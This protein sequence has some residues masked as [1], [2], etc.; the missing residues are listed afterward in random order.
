MILKFQFFYHLW[1]NISLGLH[2]CKNTFLFFFELWLNLDSKQ[3]NK[4]LFN[5][6]LHRCEPVVVQMFEYVEVHGDHIDR[7]L[8]GRQC[9]PVLHRG[10]PRLLWQSGPHI[11]RHRLPLLHLRGLDH[12]HLLCR[13]WR[14]DRP[15]QPGS[16]HFCLEIYQA[17]VI[18]VFGDMMTVC[19]NVCDIM[20]WHLPL[21]VIG[22][23]Y[24]YLPDDCGG[25]YTGDD[26]IAPV[27]LL[28]VLLLTSSYNNNPY[29]NSY[30]PYQ[31]GYQNYQNQQLFIPQSNS[32]NYQGGY[33]TS[34]TNLIMSLTG[35]R[36]G[37]DKA[38]Q[39]S[40]SAARGGFKSGDKKDYQLLF[41][42][43]MAR[44]EKDPAIYK[45]VR[46]IKNP[47][48]GKGKVVI[49]TNDIK[50][51]IKSKKFPC[52]QLV[53]RKWKKVCRQMKKRKSSD[54]KRKH[55]KKANYSQGFVN[56]FWNSILNWNPSL[57]PYPAV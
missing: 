57:T 4:L 18:N 2:W 3:W 7:D 36:S 50:S 32:Q 56:K 51:Q 39:F 12:L 46:R 49:D 37:L 28:N 22:N 16:C 48:N 26:A 54:R 13:T 34:L 45:Y 30:L 55:K 41:N 21:Q 44:L 43:G 20:T 10:L 14:P 27:N 17:I 53:K 24:S 47:F 52:K 9:V 38:G 40:G 11:H 8:G 19:Y 1:V 29:Q 42:R 31:T 15:V 25:Y 23:I 35:V 5:V 33:Q 6:C